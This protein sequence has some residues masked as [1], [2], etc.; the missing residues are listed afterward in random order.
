MK[1]AYHEQKL[2]ERTESIGIAF[3]LFSLLPPVQKV[4]TSRA[5]AFFVASNLLRS[6]PPREQRNGD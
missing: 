5:I 4:F 3:S 6:A 2:T 1:V